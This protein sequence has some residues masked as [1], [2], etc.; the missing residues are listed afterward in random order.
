MIRP[1]AL[2]LTVTSLS[3]ATLVGASAEVAAPQRLDAAACLDHH[4]S[5]GPAAA[6][7]T[8]AG[9]PAA[10]QDTIFDAASVEAVC[11][12]ASGDLHA[13]RARNAS[14][15]TSAPAK[16]RHVCLAKPRA[17]G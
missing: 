7:F 14:R 15:S 13:C 1:I 9:I 10:P 5:S 12:A 16:L 4:A 17:A 11:D 8:L 6:G 3:V 2:L